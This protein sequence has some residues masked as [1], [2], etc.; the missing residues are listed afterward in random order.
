MAGRKVLSLSLPP[1]LLKEVQELAKEEKL[2]TSEFFRQ[3]A[4][5]FIGKLKWAQAKKAGRRA[6]RELK[7][8]EDD[9]EGLIHAWRQK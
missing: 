3:A 2:T 5:D 7:I 8:D 4:T 6:V 9:I 1:T